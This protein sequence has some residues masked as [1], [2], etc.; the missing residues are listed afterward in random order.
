LNW[1]GQLSFNQTFVNFFL[2]W[3]EVNTITSIVKDSPSV[4]GVKVSFKKKFQTVLGYDFMLCFLKIIFYWSF[5]KNV[6]K[7]CVFMSEDRSGL[8]CWNASFNNISVISWQSV[9]LVEET[10][11]NHRLTNFITQYY[12]EYTS[13]WVGFELTTLVVIGTDCTDSCKSYYHRSR[14]RRPLTE[15]EFSVSGFNTCNR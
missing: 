12:I 15:V 7:L 10:G 3:M 2:Y 13:P 11:E 9:S 5:N 4:R 1:E 6:V 14:Q 8:E